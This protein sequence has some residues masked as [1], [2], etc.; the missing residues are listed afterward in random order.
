MLQARVLDQVV[1]FR[2]DGPIEQALV[3]EHFRDRLA[4][5]EHPFEEALFPVRFQIDVH[6]EHDALAVEEHGRK[7]EVV[8]RRD[9]VRRE[10]VARHLPHDVIRL[11]EG[12]DRDGSNLR[13]IHGSLLPHVRGRFFVFESSALKLREAYDLLG[14]AI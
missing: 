7:R 8:L 2:L 9:V 12:A 5:L 4:A 1:Q 11:A 14:K 3:V 13:R 6:I 10:V